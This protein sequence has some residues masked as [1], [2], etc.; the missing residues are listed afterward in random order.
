VSDRRQEGNL[1]IWLF[2]LATEQAQPLT[3][4]DWH[5]AY[6]TW[7]PDGQMLAFLSFEVGGPSFLRAVDLEDRQ[8]RT[9][10]PAKQ[11][12][13]VGEYS[14]S[15]DGKSILY[16]IYSGRTST[17]RVWRFDLETQTHHSITR[18]QG[19]IAVSADGRFLGFGVRRA[20]DNVL[21]FR[22]VRLAD[23]GI[24]QPAE[25]IYPFELAWM[26]HADVLGVVGTGIYPLHGFPGGSYIATWEAKENSLSPRGIYT[27]TQPELP[28]YFDLCDLAWSPN[29][30]KVLTVRGE[31][32]RNVCQ[33]ELFLFDADLAH[34][35]VL[36]LG[37]KAG[38]P[39]WSRD[40]R[41]IAYSVD[42]TL[43][44]LQLRLNAQ[45][46]FSGEIWVV[47]PSGT[48]ARPL[49]ANPAYNGQPVW[50]P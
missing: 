39:R 32:A 12:A 45:R 3:S 31:I 25:E 48:D 28:K 4:D 24:L 49:I 10:V 37:G 22:V 33:G 35:E 7:S 13:P 8:V 34:Y 17:N 19:P 1:D 14:W 46:Q 47:D 9:L 5:D 41:W 23:G 40:G 42:D 26:P 38:Y 21:V 43:H 29:G 18:G 50:R 6:P 44:V 15:P 30:D 20:E 2:D 36:P 11:Y 27:L 16:S